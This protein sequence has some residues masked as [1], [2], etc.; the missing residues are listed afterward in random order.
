MTR[1]SHRQSRKIVQRS[2]REDKHIARQ[3]TADG[4]I[5][6]TNIYGTEK[7]DEKVMYSS[8]LGLESNRFS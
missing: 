3:F 6:S 1:Q 8:C 7:R 5:A 4:L 2:K